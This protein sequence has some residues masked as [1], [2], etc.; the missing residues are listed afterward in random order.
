MYDVLLQYRNIKGNVDVF[1]PTF[2]YCSQ[3]KKSI[4][5]I[6]SAKQ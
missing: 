4:N 1:H 3:R 6:D 5:A 2:Q